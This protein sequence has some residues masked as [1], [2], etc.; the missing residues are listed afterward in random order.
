[1]RLVVPSTP[2]ADSPIYYENE[3]T[4]ARL[5][6]VFPKGSDNK[7]YAAVRIDSNHMLS[8]PGRYFGFLSLTPRAGWRGTYYS[9]TL[10]D[11]VSVTNV[12]TSVDETG[13]EVTETEVETLQDEEGGGL[14][15]LFELGFETSFKAFKVL[16]EGEN[17]WGDGLRHVF[18][19]YARHTYVPEPN[20]TPVQLY[21]FDDIDGLDEAHHV[22]L[23]LRNKLQTR[24]AGRN[25]HD[26]IDADLNTLYRVSKREGENDFD[27]LNTLV[28]VRPDDGFQLEFDAQYDTYASEVRE[29]N[30][31]LALIGEEQSRWDLEY[32]YRADE[33]NLIISDV[34]LFPKNR[35]S[36]GLSHRYDLD[37]SQ[38][39]EHGYWV[40]RRMECIA[41]SLG[42]THEPARDAED[43]DDY[44]VWFRIWLLALPG[45]GLDVGG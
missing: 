8:H 31:R 12:V 6:R 24:R 28:R 42:F 1:V 43:E 4:A 27:T 16:D 17:L 21:R 32:R 3:T 14:R 35:W 45:R 29:F 7:D 26:L 30:A 36:F 13:L 34:T 25:V 39:E 15:N 11:P 20:L 44:R 18:E 9:K 33:R 37:G 22:R 40:Q 23:G 38:L 41:W 19:P 10:S 2:V 5:E